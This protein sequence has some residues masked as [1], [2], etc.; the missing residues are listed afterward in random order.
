MPRNTIKRYMPTPARLRKIKV[1]QIL[2]E[3]IYDPNLWHINRHST[4][5]AFFVG[6]FVAFMPVPSQMVLASL[7]AIWLRC[8]LPLSVGLCW[9]TNP[10][11]MGPIFWFA[12]KLGALVLGEPPQ[13]EQFEV[14]LEWLANGL[15]LIWQPLLLGCLI[16]G[17]FFGSLGYVVIQGLWRWSVVQR[18]EARSLRRLSALNKANHDVA[19]RQEAILQHAEQDTTQP[20]STAEP[21]P[22]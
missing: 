18:W 19:L 1:L 20:G 17:F 5:L 4:S 7:M 11:T 16:A 9:V 21:P 2:G 22:H 10:V 12:Y 3:W 13:A 8:N 14:S 15:L 6:L